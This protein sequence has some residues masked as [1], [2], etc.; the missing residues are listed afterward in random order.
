MIAGVSQLTFTP[1]S[2]QPGQANL[3]YAMSDEADVAYAYYPTNGGPSSIGGTAWFR[4]S[5]IAGRSTPAWDA[6]LKGNYAWM[7]ILH[8]TGHTLGLKHGHEDPALTA[9]R[10]S[11]EYSVMT[12]R[13]YIGGS[14]QGAIRTRSSAIRR[15]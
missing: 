7:G 11:L 1:N 8:E 5:P 9:D 4:N 10:D 12:Y 6:P 3:R 13:S 14:I 2:F 15:R